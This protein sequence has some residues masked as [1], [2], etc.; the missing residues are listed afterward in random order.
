MVS[1]VQTFT[2]P[3]CTESCV[4]PYGVGLAMSLILTTVF[5]NLLHGTREVL[6]GTCLMTLSAIK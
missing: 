2:A 1:S 6:F 3:G 4:M 5:T